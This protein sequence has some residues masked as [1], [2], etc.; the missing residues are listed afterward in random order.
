MTETDRLLKKALDTLVTEKLEHDFLI[1][2][3][4]A[5]AAAPDTAK[6]ARGR[7]M[8]SIQAAVA[9][10]LQ[11]ETALGSPIHEVADGL[12][13]GMAGGLITFYEGVKEQVGSEKALNG[14]SIMSKNIAEALHN[15]VHGNYKTVYLKTKT[16][17]RA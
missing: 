4:D 2:E 9:Y 3:R 11:K 6:T 1:F 17:P 14:L 10:V 16:T 8:V 5:F 15:G 12:V 7:T 13:D